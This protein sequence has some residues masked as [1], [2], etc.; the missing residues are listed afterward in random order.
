MS[1][2]IS[3]I[4]PCYNQGEYIQE[5]IDSVKAQTYAFWEII[6]VDDGSNDE[7][8][9][10]KLN[11]LKQEGYKIIA[12]DNCG[13]S[14][15]R[16]KG[17]A[18]SV[19]EFILPLDADDKISADYLQEGINIM[20]AKS[21]VKLV[22]S[23]CEYF[24]IKNGLSP[25]PSFS[26]KGMLY[27]N[28]IFNSAI[29]R[30]AAVLETGGYDE[31]FLTGWEDWEFWLRYIKR[32]HEVFKLPATYFFYRIKEVSRNNSLKDDRLA[33]CEQQL[34]K[35]HVDLFLKT[36]QKPITTLKELNFYKVEFKKIEN[37]KEQLHQSLSYKIG[38]VILSPL[39]WIKKIINDR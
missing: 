31:T 22:Y 8:T 27:E 18:A 25:V 4:I 34:F 20:L 29:L 14:A 21:E 11:D 15:A 35:K 12:T 6:I 16:N 9:I 24:G 39:K 19:G 10:K 2:I 26:M 5:A 3:I 30:R 33:L 7:G 1:N 13:V 17:I 28:L 37:Y 32:E 38:D 23:D 36:M